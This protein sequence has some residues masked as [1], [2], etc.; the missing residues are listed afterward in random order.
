MQLIRRW[1]RGY[2]V[3]LVALAAGLVALYV[4]QAG[5]GFP[6]DDSWIHQ[7]YGRNLAQYGEWAFVPGEP[8]AASTSPLYTV[9][10]ALGYSVNLPY[11]LWTHFLGTL[12]LALTGIIGARM[13]ERLLPQQRLAGV[14][15]GLILVGSWHLVWAAASGMET[16]L[17][18]LFTL[19]LIALAWREMG[20]ATEMSV[21]RLLRRGAVFGAVAALAAL[22]RPE[23]VL[24]AGLCGLAVV[25]LWFPG[26]AG[27]LVSWVIGAV[28][29]FAVVIAPYLL[30]NLQLT[31]GLLPNTAA[32]KYAQFAP[33][34][35]L[36]SYP[37]RVWQ[38]IYPLL[39]GGQVLLLPGV[40]W[41]VAR[42]LMQM[43]QG[44]LKREGIV[45]LLP[46]AW[47]AGLILLYAARLPAPYQH[48]RYVI[49]AL[50]GLLL[51][52]VAGLI[53]LIERGRRSLTGRVITRALGVAAALVSA[54]FAA[55]IGPAVY[56]TDVAIIQEEMVASAHWIADHIP[57]EDYLAIH[58][59]GAVG[60]FA[61]RPILDVAGLVN[62]EVL[63]LL[64]DRE[65]L[66]AL[67][68]ERG[69]RYLLAFPDQVPGGD[70]T[71][72]R[73]CAVYTT[74]GETAPRAGGSN[75]TVYALV[76][77]RSCQ[78]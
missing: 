14:L 78:N 52:G 27:W 64:H 5:E 28:V 58:D 44:T 35:A 61:P 53:W 73:L 51:C 63:P 38:M 46:V 48:G 57:P 42:M 24:L 45:M 75:M 30:L 76:W 22:T 4:G 33:V 20:A 21:G 43:R 70:I 41:Y 31:G 74:G 10:L 9:L 62:P 12:A 17:F 50:P 7:V 72:A 15:A 69:A 8:S 23:G 47:A 71:D 40:I 36:L 65:A 32:A 59:I 60:Y 77:D 19:I 2:D 49:P 16:A 1:L 18:N 56:S 25:I 34:L 54:Y 6:L 26:M 3:L 11:V 66:Y 68:Q 55:G 13:T 37:E 67:M 29:S 39:A